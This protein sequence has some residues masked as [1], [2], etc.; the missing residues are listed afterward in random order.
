MAYE[1]KKRKSF[2]KTKEA[3]FLFHYYFRLHKPHES[4]KNSFQKIFYAEVYLNSHMI[5]SYF[6]GSD[7]SDVLVQGLTILA[8]IDSPNTDGINPGLFA[9]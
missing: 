5:I 7:C 6:C 9:T 1:I 8:P 4:M 2:S 3:Y